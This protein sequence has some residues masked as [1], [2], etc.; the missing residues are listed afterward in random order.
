[1]ISTIKSILNFF[2]PKTQ[3]EIEHDYLSKSTDH[4]DLERRIKRIE[5]GQAP[6]QAHTNN[7]LRD[8]V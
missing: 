7:N 2:A 5:R 3:R 6:F 4:A 8:W 1:M